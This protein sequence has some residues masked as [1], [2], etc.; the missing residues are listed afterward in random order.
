MSL[1]TVEEVTTALAAEVESAEELDDYA[2]VESAS[3]EALALVTK[4]LL[5]GTDD[6][7]QPIYYDVPDVIALRACVDVGRDIYYKRT[8]R[9]GIVSFNSPDIQPMRVRNDPMGAAYPIL[10]PFTG[11]GIA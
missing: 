3:G 8:A 4:H 5:R 9:N 10:Q 1:P 11:P 7:D 2:F 6:E